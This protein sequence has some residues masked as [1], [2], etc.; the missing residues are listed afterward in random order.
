[1]EYLI[2][3]RKNWAM[4]EERL[5]VESDPRRRQVLATIVEHAKAESLPD[6]ERLMATVSPHAHYRFFGDQA[7]EVV[8]KDGV[9]AFYAD[10]VETGR[11]RVEH[12]VERMV[13]DRDAVTT[14][15]PMRMA[16]PGVFLADAGI[17]VPDVDRMYLFCTRMMI[18]W[19]FDEDG[20]VHCED[21]YN[22]G[23]GWA[24]IATRPVEPSQIRPITLADL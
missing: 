24:G 17:E 9:G 5:A 6:Y 2:D 11:N 3:Q 15:G 21:S 4:A 1:M 18:V 14:E 10:L 12:A 22:A 13:V 8:G 16:Y 20:L 23:D 7:T 19:G